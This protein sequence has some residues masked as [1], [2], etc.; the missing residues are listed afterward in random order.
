M[1]S[2]SSSPL[3][4]WSMAMNHFSSHLNTASIKL[5]EITKG[6]GNASTKTSSYRKKKRHTL[7][8]LPP[9]VCW[10]SFSLTVK[11]QAPISSL[12]NYKS[13]GLLLQHPSDRK[14]MTELSEGGWACSLQPK[15]LRNQTFHSM[16]TSFHDW[17]KWQTTV[18]LN[19]KPHRLRT[20]PTDFLRGQ[21]YT[22]R[23]IAG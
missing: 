19:L 4:N 16:R 14:K 6:A 11:W 8:Y 7:C 22:I 2:Q 20:L 15:V 3:Y 23:I 1:L 5:C 10:D 21:S 12:S 13:R 18:R 9:A 17:K